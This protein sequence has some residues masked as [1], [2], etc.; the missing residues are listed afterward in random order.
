MDNPDYLQ[1]QRRCFSEGTDQRDGEIGLLDIAIALARR[2]KA[3]VGIPLIVAVFAGVIT[4]F[5]PDASVT[6]KA[7]NNVLLSG[8]SVPAESIVKII[9]NHAKG[10][11][12]AAWLN[13]KSIYHVS[14]DKDALE[15]LGKSVQ[16]SIGKDS[17]LL[18]ISVS[19]SDRAR[20]ARIA[21]AYPQI[22]DKLVKS[23]AISDASK[24]REFFERQLPGIRNAYIQSENKLTAA[25]HL[26]GFRAPEATVTALI[27]KTTNLK[28]RIA[29]KETEL[30]SMA[31]PGMTKNPEYLRL[32][33]ELNDLWIE[34]SRVDQSPSIYSKASQ[35]DLDYLRL[36]RNFRYNETRY[37]QLVK[38]IE[39]ARIDELNEKPLLRVVSETEISEQ[40]PKPKKLLIIVFSALISGFLVILWVL[41]AEAV[42]HI[43]KDIR[44][45]SRI[46][47]LSQA[48]KW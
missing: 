39:R 5:I 12:L 40:K 10:D 37:D 7:T 15:K 29:I 21:N 14:S 45:K 32:Q 3:I 13:L 43:S 22:L 44:N 2:K 30:S 6:Y 23:F 18:D 25:Q 19:D 4:L 1:G 36:L 34:F 11:S 48:L 46:D 47:A 24:K 27:E 35:K 16:A 20:A 41:F 38:E 17:T 8:G 9:N 28:A 26:P 33:K 31:S 42:A